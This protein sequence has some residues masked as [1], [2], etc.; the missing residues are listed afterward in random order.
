MPVTVKP[1]P[2]LVG[3]NSDM[4][5]H[6]AEELL[7]KTSEAW[8]PPYQRSDWRTGK[9]VEPENRPIIQSSFG[10]LDHATAVIPYGNGMVNGIIRAFQQDLHLVLRPD[11]VWLSILTQFSMF[12]NAN[13]EQLRAHFVDH[14]GKKKLSID[15]RPY[16]I[17]D[18][19][20]GKFA[21]EM[22]LLIEKNV[23]DLKLRNWIIPNFSTTTNND[24]SVA[25]VVMM[26]TLQK[27]FEYSFMCGCGFPSVTLLGE[28]ADWEEI[29]RR[30]RKLPKYGS[31][32]TEWSLLLIPIIK[33]MVKSFDQP[34]SQQ[35]K[36][37]WLRAC[38]SAGQDGSLEIE[39]MSGWITAF[40]FW[41]EDG[42]RMM[43]YSDEA[44]QGGRSM[45]P[46]ADRKRLVLDNTAYPIIRRSG[47][48][49]GVVSVPVIIRDDAAELVYK[50][51]MVAGSVGMTATAAG[52]G[53]GLTTVQPRSGWWML[54]DSVKPIEFDG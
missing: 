30:V 35:V 9:T 16:P 27:Y 36:D 12:V 28:R 8:S 37:F 24:K 4:T 17:W 51:T 49:N 45:V 44:L 7:K 31:Q 2:E 13:A 19:E 32:P 47:I 52:G 50:T 23:V 43:N 18:V 20:M 11:D 41:S 21:Q 25:S 6:S 48:P 15:V 10:D 40:C 14:E 39:T 26:G 38:H 1:S 53:E 5:A 3:R 22:T 46:L 42:T 34:D 54:Q 29:L 33:L